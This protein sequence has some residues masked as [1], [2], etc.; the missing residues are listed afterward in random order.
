MLTVT[1][2]RP[3]EF[4]YIQRLYSQRDSDP[5]KTISAQIRAMQMGNYPQDRPNQPRV[6]RRVETDETD[7]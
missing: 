3:A 7:M 5:M 6:M 4:D 2:V 1:F